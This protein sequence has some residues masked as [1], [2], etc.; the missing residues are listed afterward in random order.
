MMGHE[1]DDPVAVLPCAHTCSTSLVTH[2]ALMS[3]DFCVLH[4]QPSP[5]TSVGVHSETKGDGL[6][7]EELHDFAG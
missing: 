2:H 6:H 4:G 1:K 7:L 3:V 5:Q